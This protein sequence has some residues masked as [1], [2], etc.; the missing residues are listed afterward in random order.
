[1]GLCGACAALLELLAEGAVRCCLLSSSVVGGG[2]KKWFLDLLGVVAGWLM[3]F[4]VIGVWVHCCVSAVI[5]AVR[6]ARRP[7][8][9]PPLWPACVT[10]SLQQ[11]MGAGRAGAVDTLMTYGQRI[12]VTGL[13][14]TSLAGLTYI[15][16]AFADMVQKKRKL[17]QLQEQKK[18]EILQSQD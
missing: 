2:E 14:L 9:T 12:L 13:A 17:K 11:R 18:Q 5:L 6:S 4:S 16:A 15:S 10:A 8:R 1:M 3:L 7:R